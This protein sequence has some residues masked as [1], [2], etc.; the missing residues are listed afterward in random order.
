MGEKMKRLVFG[1]ALCFLCSSAFV[2]GG[3]KALCPRHIE[4][5]DYPAVA[6]VAHVTGRFTLTVTIDAEGDVTHVDATTD[7][8]VARAHPL[9]QKYA[10]ANMERWTFPKP[11]YAPYTQDISYDYELSADLPASG[12]RHGLPVVTKVLFDLP[13]RV[14]ILTN[15]PMME[16][17]SSQSH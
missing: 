9:L 7:N 4:A 2:Q 12:G 3:E 8:P 14:T 16:P 5:P 10:I 13:D 17:S 15:V 11:P 6:R 1:C